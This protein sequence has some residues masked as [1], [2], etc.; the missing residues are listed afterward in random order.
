MLKRIFNSAVLLTALMLAGFD[1][2]AQS[3]EYLSYTPY[4]IFGIGDLSL[5]GSAYNRSMGG[6]GI[7]S[8]NVRYLNSLNPAA[9]T[10]RDTLSFMLDFTVTNS[11]TIYA[12][13]DMKSAK[14]ISNIGSMTLSFPIWRNLAMMAGITPYSSGGYG[15]SAKETDPAVIA[16]TGNITYYDYGQGSL[17]KVFAAAGYS[18]WKKLSVGAEADYIF[19]N[20]GKYFTETFSNSGYNTAQD[21]YTLRLNAFTGKFG[22]QYEQNLGTKAK[23]GLGATYALGTSLNG[24]VAYNHQSVGSAETVD[25]TAVTD[26]LGSGAVKLASEI[27]LGVSLT[28]EDRFRAEIDCI[29]AD[30]TGT[31]V[32]KVD[33]FA[34]ANSALPFSATTRRGI[35]AGVEYTPD[36]YNVRYYTRRI[37]YRAGAY[38]NNEYY[39]VAGNEINNFGITLGATLPVRESYLHNGISVSLDLGQRGTANGGLVRERYIKIGVGLNLH[40]IWFRK[41]R[42]E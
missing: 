10:A 25:V 14:N 40:D 11:N 15:Y 35:R 31:G 19:G 21:S 23:L 17:Y 8:R 26:T 29:M 6:V 36:R 5:P 13:G 37:S 39:K 18:F 38:Y 4:S 3:G 27:G 24:T 34:N 2:F 28:I 41:Y 30:W 7:A 16:R 9:V 33:G 22:A 32:D 12:Q 1:S 42:Y 20:Y